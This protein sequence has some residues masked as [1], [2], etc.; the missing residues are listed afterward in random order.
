MR[1]E[2]PHCGERDWSEFRYGG[3]AS[4][5]RP[6]HG[7]GDL[8]SWHDYVFL[9]DNK[10]APHTE[11][12]QHVLGCRQWFKLKRNTATNEIPGDGE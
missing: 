7:T 2:C 8:K 10:K 11:N 9:F 6:A 4:K 1:I 5:T 12:W 3:D